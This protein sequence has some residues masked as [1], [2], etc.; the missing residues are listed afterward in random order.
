MIPYVWVCGCYCV[1]LIEGMGAS[2]VGT[3]SQC[4]RRFMEKN[5]CQAKREKVKD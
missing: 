4:Q 3:T 2:R 1:Q 5:N